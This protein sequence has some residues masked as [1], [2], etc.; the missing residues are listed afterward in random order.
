MRLAGSPQASTLSDNVLKVIFKNQ[1]AAEDQDA[2][3][4]SRYQRKTELS[5]AHSLTTNQPE[6]DACSSPDS[7]TWLRAARVESGRG[8]WWGLDIDN[9]TGGYF[10]GASICF[11]LCSFKAKL[12]EH[13]RRARDRCVCQAHSTFITHPGEPAFK[14]KSV[15]FVAFL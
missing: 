14:Q 2:F 12:N 13:P 15:S 7:K 11:P 1:S 5:T 10:I 3:R 4:S 9:R 8:Q 6:E